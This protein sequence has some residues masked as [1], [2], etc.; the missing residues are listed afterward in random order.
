MSGDAERTQ[1]QPRALVVS[2]AG[3]SYVVPPDYPG[4]FAIGRGSSCQIVIDSR[5]VSRLHGCIRVNNGRYSYRDTSSNGTVVTRGHDE[6]LV[7][8]SEVELP[9]AGALRIGDALLHFTTR[10]PSDASA[11]N[12]A[13]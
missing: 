4:L 8:D 13:G 2:H 10:P 1:M 12:H 6:T 5:V 11:S 9:E 7:Y 3:R